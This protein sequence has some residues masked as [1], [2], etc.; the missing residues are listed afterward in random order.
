MAKTSLGPMTLLYP[1]PALL[2]GANVDGKPNFM[3]AAW[4]GIADST[5][6]MLTVAIQT[7]QYTAIG[8]RQNFSLSVNIP[9]TSQ[10]KET[11]FCGMVKGSEVDKVEACGFNLFYGKLGTAPMI[12]QCP[13]NLECYVVNILELGSH[14]LFVARIEETYV[15]EECL[16]DGRPDVDK[17]KPFIYVGSPARQY[18][19]FGEVVGKAYSAGKVIRPALFPK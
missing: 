12:D 3:T 14:F 16:T 7:K 5:P 17:I 4:S 8:I 9:S 15:S 6:P 19:A 13:V 18:R 11:D 10:V 2:I 1:Y